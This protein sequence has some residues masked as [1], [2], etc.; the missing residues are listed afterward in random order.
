[1]S[2]YRA[3]R[4]MDDP[5]AR[6]HLARL[7]E[8]RS[9]CRNVTYDGSPFDEWQAFGDGGPEDVDAEC[10]R[11]LT[12]WQAWER[13]HHEDRERRGE[14]VPPRRT[15]GKASKRR[16][17]SGQVET[18][19]RA[20]ATARERVSASRRVIR[21]REPSGFTDP[22]RM[23]RWELEELGTPEAR[24]ELERRDAVRAEK[25]ARRAAKREAVA[26]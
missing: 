14:Y 22:F 8:S 7:D 18:Q 10:D 6:I 19:A 24:V 9:L 17:R 2:E 11:C 20:I 4:N 15:H 21:K 12:C 26:A 16:R 25:K 3:L 13:E 5:G 1:M 23:Y